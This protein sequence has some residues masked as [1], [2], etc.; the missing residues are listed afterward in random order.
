MQYPNVERR[1]TGPAWMD[2]T[3]ITE[4]QRREI[5]AAMEADKA[6]DGYARRNF[7][8]AMDLQAKRQAATG[9]TL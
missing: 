1:D 5:D 6:A 7:Q 2:K 9:E 4:A 8:R 3:A